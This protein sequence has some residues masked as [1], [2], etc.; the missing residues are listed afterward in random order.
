MDDLAL[1]GELV[2]GELVTV[3]KYPDLGSDWVS[4]EGVADG[5]PFTSWAWVSVWLRHLP[6]RYRPMVF[7]ACDPTGLVALGL[8]VDVPER[9]I[10]RLFGNRSI[11]M[12]ETGATDLDEVT[13]EY[14]GLLI[15]RGAETRAYAALF[16]ELTRRDRRWRSLR[17]SASSHAR[18]V[19]EALPR[20]LCAFSAN[21]QPCY[22]VDLAQLRREGGNYPACLSSRTRNLLRKTRRAYEALGPVRMAVAHE[23]RQALDWL[24]EMRMLHD[25]HWQSKGLRGSF[26]SRFFCAFHSD[27]VRAG[28][29]GGLTQLLRVSAGPA[30]IGYLYNL[31]WRKRVYFYNTGLNYGVLDRHDRPGYLGHLLA[32]EKYLVEGA[33]SY[34]FLAGDQQYKR[35]LGT[36]PVALHWIDIRPRGWRL[37][38]E[39]TLR[40]MSRRPLSDLLARGS[41]GPAADHNI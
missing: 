26:A 11:R 5:S 28:T 9:G 29:R 4:L 16:D 31:L 8:L 35:S 10:K 15:R 40:A 12:Q 18:A 38:L 32:I 14:T 27:L 39:H 7:R 37:D 41:I 23:P 3:E 13:I 30:T 33:D 20:P 6:A 25:R 24:G 21:T 22:L 2:T 36:H 1:K 17:I 19:C 34:D